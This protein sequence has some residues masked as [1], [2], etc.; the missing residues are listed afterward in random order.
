MKKNFFIVLFSVFLLLPTLGGCAQAET[1]EPITFTEEELSRETKMV[2]NPNLTGELTFRYYYGLSPDPTFRDNAL[3]SMYRKYFPNVDLRVEAVDFAN[4]PLREYQ[5]QLATE[6]MAGSGPDVVFLQL[7]GEAALNPYKMMQAGAFLDL[8]DYFRNDSNCNPSDFYQP[9]MEAGRYQGRQY[10]VPVYFQ[11]PL[12]VTTGEIAEQ[13]GF[14]PENCVDLKS[15]W[16]ELLPVLRENPM[17]LPEKEMVHY[18]YTPY[19]APAF[20]GLPWIDYETQEVHLD[21]PRLEEYCAFIKDELS[22][23]SKEKRIPY[24]TYDFSPALE[25]GTSHFVDLA[26]GDMEGLTRFNFRYLNL[27]GIDDIIL[28][29]WQAMDGGSEALINEAIGATQNCKN[30]EAAYQLIKLWI[31][32]EFF[33]NLDIWGQDQQPIANRKAMEAYMRLMQEPMVVYRDNYGVQDAPGLSQDLVEQYLGILNGITSARLS[34]PELYMV[35]DGLRDYF[36]GN[37][38]YE[39][40]ISE[41]QSKLEIYVTE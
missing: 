6:I 25:Q 32:Q 41:L 16:E 20:T 3:Y 28:I 30:P 2:P 11:C 1:L 15:T 7:Q 39:S 8:T 14:H 35:Q 24:Y 33:A 34:S 17:N 13:T 37:R 5:I 21:D 27:D 18:L 40:C 23:Y 29:P 31:S 36:N 9:V 26:T 22:L 38:S 10:L 12:I 4:T 19:W